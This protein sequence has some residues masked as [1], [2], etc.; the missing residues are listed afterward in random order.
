MQSGNF[1]HEW[2]GFPFFFISMSWYKASATVRARMVI[3]AL[4]EIQLD[5]INQINGIR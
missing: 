2:Y 1:D 4:N 5:T 3:S